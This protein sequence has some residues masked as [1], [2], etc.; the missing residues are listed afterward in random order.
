M[1]LARAARALIPDPI[2]AF[3]HLLRA[4]DMID[5]RYA[6]PLDVPALAREA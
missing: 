2:P 1:G 4:K 3:I 6:E 5:R